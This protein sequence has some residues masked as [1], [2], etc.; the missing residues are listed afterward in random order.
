MPRGC[1]WTSARVPAQPSAS[2]HAPPTV[3]PERRLALATSRLHEQQ[4][5]DICARN[6]Q[7]ESD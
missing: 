6:D 3:E 2:P 5:A 7:Q 4:V 1:N